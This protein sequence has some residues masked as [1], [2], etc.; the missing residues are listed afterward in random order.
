[1]AWLEKRGSRYHLN[2]EFRGQ[3]FSR[4]LRTSDRKEAD[5]CRKK[6]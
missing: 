2:L 1:M 6:G 4:S 5:G 3:H